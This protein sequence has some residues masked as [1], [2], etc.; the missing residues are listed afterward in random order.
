MIEL[1]K[2]LQCFKENN[3][4]L[5]NRIDF[6]NF[7]FEIENIIVSLTTPHSGNNYSYLLRADF[8]K[9]FD[10]WSNCEFE[11]NFKTN[12]EMLNAISELN[13]L[14]LAIKK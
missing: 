5:V 3:F 2:V 9:N 11:T 14:Y 10:R 4:K 12:E 1:D 13:E 7:Y 6:D 8:K